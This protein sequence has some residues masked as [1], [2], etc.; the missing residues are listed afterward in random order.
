[1][2]NRS[3]RPPAKN[4]YA[5]HP[6][7]AAANARTWI[8]SCRRLRPPGRYATIENGAEVVSPVDGGHGSDIAVAESLEADLSPASRGKHNVPARAAPE[9]QPISPSRL[10]YG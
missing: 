5:K 6:R 10:R 7:K 3:G 1:M 8:I 4:E 2:A 9:P